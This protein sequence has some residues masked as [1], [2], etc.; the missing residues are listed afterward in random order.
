MATTPSSRHVSQA[1]VEEILDKV[2]TEQL[3]EDTVDE[4]EG[5]TVESEIGMF[6]LEL[7][8]SSETVVSAGKNIEDINLGI[9]QKL[10]NMCLDKSHATCLTIILLILFS[11]GDS[12]SD[13]GMV[14][15][16]FKANFITEAYL[17]L[18]TD[19]L[20]VFLTLTNFFMS[21]M[22]RSLSLKQQTML[23]AVFIILS[24]FVPPICNFLWLVCALSGRQNQGV[25]F[26]Y[27]AKL[28]SGINGTFEV[29]ISLKDFC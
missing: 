10:L 11:C 5:S 23:A 18:V 12:G 2:I 19:Y 3:T 1:I 15:Y 28:T 24:P 8:D 16:F 21:S 14:F 9:F 4:N 27:L 20:P 25:F 29:K 17:V 6:A 7:H 22:R 26:H 13:L